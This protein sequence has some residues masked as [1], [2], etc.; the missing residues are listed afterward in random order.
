M[1]QYVEASLLIIVVI[2]VAVVVSAILLGLGTLLARVFAVTV[3]EA[4]VLVSAVLVTIIWLLRTLLLGEGRDLEEE[5]RKAPI[6]TVSPP[7]VPGRGEKR[8][9]G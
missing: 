2:V 1:R 7:S 6:I 4:A 8:R 3:F 5:L 9:R